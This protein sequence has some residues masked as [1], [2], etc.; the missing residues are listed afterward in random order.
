MAVLA[1]RD[2][3]SHLSEVRVWYDGEG[4]LIFIY[5]KFSL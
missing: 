5:V 2:V 3:L 1:A 4:I